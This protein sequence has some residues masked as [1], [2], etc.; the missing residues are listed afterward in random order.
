MAT[1]STLISPCIIVG[2]LL[3]ASTGLRAADGSVSGR[4]TDLQGRPVA[5]AKVSLV[6]RRDSRTQDTHSDSDGR[7][8]FY[9]LP[10]GAY[11]I[12]GVALGFVDT[13]R[14]VNIA[15]GGALTVNLQFDRLASRSE[16]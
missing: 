13:S 8:A 10:A 9:S 12:V 4:L 11:K 2:L 14:T 1:R 15:D 16:A 5:D 6:Q 7:F 3:V